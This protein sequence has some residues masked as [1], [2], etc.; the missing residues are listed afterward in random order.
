MKLIS[1]LHQ[2]VMRVGFYAARIAWYFEI[3]PVD[4]ERYSPIRPG[5]VLLSIMGFTVAVYVY[6]LLCFIT[7]FVSSLTTFML[8]LLFV[9]VPW[10]L[11]TAI[12]CRLYLDYELR[13]TLKHMTREQ[14][15]LYD[16]ENKK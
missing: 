2:S 15:L 5:D 7:F 11:W 9:P 10:F 3:I 13:Q 4:S 6:I 12:F 14:R 16:Q 8:V 1:L